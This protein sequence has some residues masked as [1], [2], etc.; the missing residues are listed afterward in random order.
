MTDSQIS[1][2]PSPPV[3]GSVATAIANRRNVL[4]LVA[5]GLA[6][7]GA[8]LAVVPPTN[9]ISW[10][11]LLSAFILGI[12]GVTRKGQT[13]VT[14]IIAIAVSFVF[15]IVSIFVG[16]ALVA[17]GLSTAIGNQDGTP[18]VSQPSEE[19]SDGKDETEGEEAGAGIGDTV[20]TPNGAEVDLVSI[21]YG[22]PNPND[23]LISEVRG[24]LAAVRM[25]M[26]NNTDEAVA[27]S[28]ASV[29]GYIGSAK[30]E[31]AAVLGDSGSWYVYEEINPGLTASFTAYIDI[32]AETQ[33]DSVEFLTALLFGESAVFLAR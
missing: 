33:L 32:P 22:V 30:Y 12:V 29:I 25:T 13:K 20:T 7:L 26:T 3:E 18:S 2:P 1:T 11:F 23:I 27:I 5:L 15:W 28:G 10:L 19:S 31:A 8:L 21:D 17:S 24:S 16:V 14:S 9:G 4:G 6:V